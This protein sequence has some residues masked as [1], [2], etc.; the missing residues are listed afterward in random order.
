MSE[1][2]RGI[3]PYLALVGLALL[4]GVSFYLIKIVIRDLSPT[5]LLLLRSASGCV[6]LAIIVSLMGRPLLGPGWRARVPSFAIMA[7]TN[8]VIPWI[9]IAWGEEHISSGLASI[10]NST[11]TVWTAVL[12]YWIVPSER[13]TVV[14]Y[15]GVLLGFAGVVILVFPDLARHG[16]SGS[17]L[18]A[19]AVVVASLSYA[20]SAM[21]QR[22]KL[23]EV[24]IFEISLGQITATVLLA[25][26]IAAPSVPQVHLALP[27]IAAAIALGAGGTGIGYLLYFYVMNS[28][29]AVRASGVTLLVP[30]TA[31]FWGVALLHESLSLGIV[32]G[33]AVILAGILL[34]NF[35]RSSRTERAAEADPAAA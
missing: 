30:V 24:S 32:A 21:Y 17:F 13:P 2:R 22:R 34:I 31:V 29:G 27:S 20:V 33:M 16:V 28:L 6:T 9:A 10:L 11:T 7:V 3:L 35:R 15:V 25:V 19:V 12:I 1:S 14:N 23:R 5:V 26:P 8:A 4:W 18:G